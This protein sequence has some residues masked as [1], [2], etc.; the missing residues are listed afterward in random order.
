MKKI[1]IDAGA[2]VGQSIAAWL[3]YINKTRGDIKQWEIHSFEASRQLWE[4]LLENTRR[5]VAESPYDASELDITFYNKAVWISNDGVAFHDM[6]NESSSTDNRKAGVRKMKNIA[7]NIQSVDLSEF[8]KNYSMDDMIVLKMDIEGGEYKVIPHLYETG[9]LKYVDICLLEIH[10]CKMFGEG[11]S[12][13]MDYDL[14]KMLAEC[15]VEVYT[16]DAK[17][18]ML[19]AHMSDDGNNIPNL[20]RVSLD[21]DEVR[22]EWAKQNRYEWK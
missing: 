18:I 5:V 15:D 3:N 14:I 22:R 11:I 4:T 1:F 20:R 13:E 16:W 2:N 8:I 12:I 21:S 19:E 17:R 6:G 7:I 10:A 9:A